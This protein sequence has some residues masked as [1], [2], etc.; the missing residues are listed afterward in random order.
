LL[1]RGAEIGAM[2]LALPE[3]P[4]SAPVGDMAGDAAI[5][6]AN[7]PDRTAIV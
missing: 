3:A 5:A 7:E 4:P 1:A 6:S 2:D